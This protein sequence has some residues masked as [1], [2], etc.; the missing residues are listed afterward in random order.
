MVIPI[1]L[2][3]VQY[4]IIILRGIEIQQNECKPEN[5]TASIDTIDQH[6][7]VSI[8]TWIYSYLFTIFL[9]QFDDGAAGNDTVLVYNITATHPHGPP[10]SDCIYSVQVGHSACCCSHALSHIVYQ[11]ILTVPKYVQQ[12]PSVTSDIDYVKVP[13]CTYIYI[14]VIT[15]YTNCYYI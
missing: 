10:L 9:I 8:D 4:F 2:R 12:L 14:H 3:S 7:Q 5:F 15:M 13:P 11:Q 1:D 6:S